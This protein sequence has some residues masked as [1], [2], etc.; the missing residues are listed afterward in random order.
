MD[1]T[2]MVFICQGDQ[3]WQV[4]PTDALSWLS[5]GWQVFEPTVDEIFLT[6]LPHLLSVLEQDSSDDSPDLDSSND[7]SKSGAIALEVSELTTKLAQLEQL[8]AT[9]WI[10]EIKQITEHVKNQKS[11]LEEGIAQ[12]ERD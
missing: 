2:R 5:K 10:P 11:K 1:Q 8:V 4:H 3:K 6:E 9:Y 7:Q 12:Y